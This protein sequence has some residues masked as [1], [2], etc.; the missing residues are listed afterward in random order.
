[1]D[2]GYVGPVY[3]ALKADPGPVYDDWRGAFSVDY[4]SL[5]SLQNLRTVR[6]HYADFTDDPDEIP[7]NA[8]TLLVLQA[9]YGDM[10]LLD[11]S[12]SSDPR[13][14]IVDF[15]KQ[16]DLRDIKYDISFDIFD[17]FLAALRR[18]KQEKPRAFNRAFFRSQP[19]GNL[20]EVDRGAVFWV[21]DN[22][23]F[24]NMAESRDD[25]WRPQQTADERLITETEHRIEL[26][27]PQ[28]LKILWKARNGGIVAYRYIEDDSG[29]EI[30]AF[31]ELA[32]LEYVV[33]LAALS[34]RIDFTPRETPWH[35]AIA[36]ADK[37]IVLNVRRDDIILLDYRG[38]GQPALLLTKGFEASQLDA[39]HVFPDVDA[40]IARLRKFMR[41]T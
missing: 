19:L 34:R 35:E 16:H 7:A 32:P 29:E 20:P 3:V 26:P 17:S 31:E 8:D 13:V 6:E 41:Q 10:T 4:S 5:Y 37:L 18:P 40:A 9:R 33:S 38:G 23:P 39:A 24:A 2:G 1:M 15:G 30:E 14:Q 11:Y 36:D 25:G 22:H 28:A 21:G 12:R 27:L